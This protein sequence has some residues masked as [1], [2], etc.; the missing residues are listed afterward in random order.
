MV[1]ASNKKIE[2]FKFFFKFKPLYHEL[3]P[4]DRLPQIAKPR[5][6]S[7]ANRERLSLESG[8]VNEYLMSNWYN[9]RQE[10]NQVTSSYQS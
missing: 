4:E 10:A 8:K 1:V 2:I 7:A 6:G 5:S 9:K 3:P